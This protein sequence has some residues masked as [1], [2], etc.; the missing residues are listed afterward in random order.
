MRFNIFFSN[1]QKNLNCPNSH[2][3]K[4]NMHW[5]MGNIKRIRAVQYI[6]PWVLFSPSPIHST[7]GP[8]S[9]PERLPVMAKTMKM[10]IISHLWDTFHLCSNFLKHHR[11]NRIK[12]RDNPIVDPKVKT[13]S[14]SVLLSPKVCN[15]RLEIQ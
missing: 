13:H 8:A 14:T 2:P 9:F 1:S 12:I 11:K 5:Y 4:T 3:T 15:K 10:A 7:K 6:A